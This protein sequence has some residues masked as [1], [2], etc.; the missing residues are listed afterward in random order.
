MLM[1][2]AHG[3]INVL[4]ALP[5]VWDLQG[6]V[7]GMKAMGN[8]VVDFQW[9]E[10]K[11]EYIRIV[12]HAGAALRVRCARGAK[13]MAEASVFV[14]GVAVD[15]EVDENGIATIPCEKGNTVVVEFVEGAGVATPKAEQK[16]GK[17]YMLDGREVTKMQPNTIYIVD[18][19]KVVNK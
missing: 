5:K 1:Q 12:S 15:V 14:D 10:G 19:K 16:N 9:T 3:Y 8:F 4:P 11:C 7:T 6:K 18:G 17:I 13:S 2:S